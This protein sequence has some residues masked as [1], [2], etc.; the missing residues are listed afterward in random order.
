[1]NLSRNYASSL[2]LGALIAAASTAR[3]GDYVDGTPRI[4]PATSRC[5]A[6]GPGFVDMG[7]GTCTRVNSHIRVEFGVRRAMNEAW[8]GGGTSSA[9]LRSD[10]IEMVPGVGVSHQLRVRN[11]LQTLSPY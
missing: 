2:A 10:G 8:S 3:A 5:A 11:T 4:T 1:M 6:F 9:T 7:N